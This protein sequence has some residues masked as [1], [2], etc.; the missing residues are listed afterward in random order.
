MAKK[1]HPNVSSISSLRQAKALA[2]LTHVK[3]Q[4]CRLHLLWARL[5]KQLKY[6][7]AIGEEYTTLMFINLD[8]I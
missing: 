6:L 7:H 8:Q 1:C 2:L 5:A 4:R 3:I